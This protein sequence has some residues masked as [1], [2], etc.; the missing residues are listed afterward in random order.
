MTAGPAEIRLADQAPVAPVPKPPAAVLYPVAYSWFIVLAAFD[1]VLTAL[2][3]S[4]LFG[5]RGNELNAIAAWVIQVFGLPGMVFY[6]YVNVAIVLVICEIVGR[7]RAGIGR[8]LA[9]W[10]VALTAVPVVVSI[11]MVIVDLS[12]AVLPVE[13]MMVLP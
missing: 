5:D 12:D 1:I 7:R 3:L 11:V 2:I 13:P 4:P 6:K 8:R 10:A 9:E